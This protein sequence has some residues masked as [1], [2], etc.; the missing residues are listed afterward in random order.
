MDEIRA[1]K[2]RQHPHGEEIQKRFSS[3]LMLS[4]LLLNKHF[5]SKVVSK[6][7]I[8]I[9]LHTKNHPN[10]TI[11]KSIHGN[12]N[13]DALPHPKIVLLT[14]VLLLKKILS[15]FA[16]KPR[17][18]LH[19]NCVTNSLYTRIQMGTVDCGKERSNLLSVF[20]SSF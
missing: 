3:P 8:K 14:T 2:Y 19:Q 18:Y 9:S 17:F 11:K 6:N 4:N 16:R 10:Y 5:F 20:K 1:V 13:L 7:K 15:H 12:Q